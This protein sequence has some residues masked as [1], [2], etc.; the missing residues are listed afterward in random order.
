MQVGRA[1]KPLGACVRRAHSS[2]G[3]PMMGQVGDVFSSI[4]VYNWP[5]PRLAH[6]L[7]NT[8]QRTAFIFVSDVAN[9]LMYP[10]IAP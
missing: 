5:A 3:E 4:L 2:A 7:L 1:L 8:C 9:A 6:F 10:V